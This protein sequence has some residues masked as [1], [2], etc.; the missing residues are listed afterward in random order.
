[1]FV[2]AMVD[3]DPGDGDGYRSEVDAGGAFG[4][5]DGPLAVTVESGRAPRVD[6]SLMDPHPHAPWSY[7]P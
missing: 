6:I 3:A 1:V 2:L 5:Y 7:G 4:G